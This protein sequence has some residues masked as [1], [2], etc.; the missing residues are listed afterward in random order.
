MQKEL[1]IS[2]T[3]QET[4]IAM[5]EGTEG[6]KVAETLHVGF[7][8]ACKFYSYAT[9]QPLQSDGELCAERELSSAGTKHNLKARLP[10][11]GTTKL[12][13]EALYVSNAHYR[14]AGAWTGAR[15]E[16][17]TRRRHG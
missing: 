9:S 17:Q 5:F 16:R 6:S 2:T 14:S 13:R 3:S 10:E 8:A 11:T 1:I 7:Y 4:K 15:R 12:N